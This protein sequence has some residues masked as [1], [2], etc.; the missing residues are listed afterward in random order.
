MTILEFH[1]RII[2]TTKIIETSLARQADKEISEDGTNNRRK[3]SNEAQ[4][5][6]PQKSV[7][8]C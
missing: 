4:V 5:S 2:K 7:K 3:S 6:S 8:G 1:K